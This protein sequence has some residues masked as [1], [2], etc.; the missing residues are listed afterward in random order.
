MELHHVYVRMK[1]KIDIYSDK[2]IKLIDIAYITAPEN[3]REV[4]LEIPLSP[5]LNVNDPYQ[6]IE[7][8]TI[9][10]LIKKQFPHTDL[11][12]LG[13][14]ETIIHTVSK[15]KK[16]SKLLVFFVWLILFIGTAMTMINFH[17]D[18]NMQEVQ[19]KLHFILTGEFVHQPL[20]LQIPYSFGLG[21]GMVLFLN[22]WFKKKINEEPSPLEIELYNYQKNIDDYITHYEN[23]LNDR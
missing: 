18:V 9:G 14:N 23:D 1:H 8:F 10:N 15:R 11:Q 6:V 22:H 13:P 19:Q 3:I 7:A 21:L 12:F 17:Y 20:W 5:L 2:E 4:I 16:A